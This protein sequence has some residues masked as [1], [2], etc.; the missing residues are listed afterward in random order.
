MSFFIPDHVYELMRV[1]NENGFECFIVGG[2][3]RNYLLQIPVHDYDLTTNALPEEMLE[4]F[5][6][7]HTIRTGLQHGTLTVMN[8]HYPVEITTYRKDTG[9]KDHRHPDQVIFTSALKEDCMRR[10]FT[11]NA[12]CFHPDTGIIDFF[13]GQEDLKNRIIRC[14]G[15]AEDRFNEDA[16]RILRAI[17]FSSR[18]DFRIEEKTAE[19]VIKLKRSLVYISRE[20]IHDEF[21]GILEGKG[22]AKL[23]DAYRSVIEEFIPGLKSLSA[24]QWAEHMACIDRSPCSYTVRAATLLR[25]MPDP[26]GILQELKYSGQEIRTVTDMIRNASLDLSSRASVRQALRILSVPF[27]DYVQFRK[28]CDP[29]L[30]TDAVL[31]LYDIIRTNNDACTLK[32]LDI[33]GT[34]LKEAGFS[35][36]QIGTALNFLLDQVIEEKV[37]NKKEALLAYL[38]QHFF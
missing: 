38:S 26:K 8:H 3:V 21:N 13:G 37:P 9:Y 15:S 28:A 30:D 1:L 33:N 19:A 17:R 36:K 25:T 23:L 16:L 5:R 4:V 34:D 24:E 6:S 18:L 29:A 35:G 11:V 2:A 10:D 31:A 27:A 32:D 14:I 20:R 12:L 7:Y 22:C